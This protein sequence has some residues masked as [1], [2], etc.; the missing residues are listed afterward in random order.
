MPTFQPQTA[1]FKE[2][3]HSSFSAQQLLVGIGA[4]LV[5]VEPGEVVIEL[6]FRSDLTQQHGFVHAGIVTA[7][8]DSACGYAALTLMRADAAVLTVEYKVNFIA[9]A[10]GN[11]FLATGRVIKPGKTI[12]VCTGEVTAIKDGEAKTIAAMQATMMAVLNRPDVREPR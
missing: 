1:D 7:I 4:R 2:R 8:V 6:P 5:R 10:A 11:S 9:P 3:V 12:T